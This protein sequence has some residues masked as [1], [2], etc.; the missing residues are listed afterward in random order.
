M[1]IAGAAVSFLV[2]LF[3]ARLIGVTGLGLFFLSVTVVEIGATVARLGLET[4][5][6]KS[7]AIARSSGDH[8]GIAALYRRCIGIAAIS[9]IVVALLGWLLLQLSSAATSSRSE[10]LPHVPL[11]AC[12]LVPVTLLPIQTE[13][14]KAMGRP[15]V[16]IFLQIAFPQGLLLLFGAVL[17]WQGRG[18]IEAMLAAYVLAFSLA[19]VAS[20]IGWASITGQFW[21]KAPV[22]SSTLLRTSL[23]ML[24]VSGLNLAMAWTDTIA[25]GLFAGADQVGIYGV[26]LRIASTTAFI[27]IAA[28]SVIAPEFAAL[29]AGGKHADLERLAQRSGLLTLVVASPM[30]FIFLVF[31]AEILSL[32]GE[33]FVAGAWPLRILTLAQL[34]N[35][36]TGQVVSLLLMTGHTNAMRNNIALSAAL[37][38]VG[39]LMLVPLL[40]ALGA[41]ISTAFS[42]ALMNIFAWWYARRKLGIDLLGYLNPLSRW[43][44]GRASPANRQDARSRPG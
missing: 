30:I 13:A 34:I 18:S 4:A 15:G 16:A 42:L 12:A 41:A 14:L 3:I 28:N 22:S 6:L 5:G 38:V 17:A 32:F 43:L 8:A 25:L 9:A 44:P 29:H 36:S 26:A 10:L 11:L 37:N 24:A 1:Q 39:N 19:V 20:G 23:P 35:V 21:L 40:G 2:T 7:I 27:R 33:A 31:P